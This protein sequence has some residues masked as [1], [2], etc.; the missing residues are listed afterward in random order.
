M[1]IDDEIQL[2]PATSGEGSIVPEGRYTLH[3][4]ALEKAPP[5]TFK[6]ED[7]PRVKWIF[8]LYAELVESLE[9]GAQFQFDGKPYEFWR[10]TSTKN[11]PRAFAR[12]YAEALG[13][14][15]LEDQEVPKLGALIGAKMSAHFG[16]DDD[17]DDP[18]RKILTL[19][20]LRHVSPPP[21]AAATAAAPKAANGIVWPEIADDIDRKLTVSKLRKSYERL[22]K[23]DADAAKGAKAAILASDLQESLMDDLNALSDEVS[24]AVRAAMED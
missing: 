16:Y 20:G 19:T 17:P 7:G 1:T 6:P 3:L 2:Q 10:T 21:A 9:R 18:T 8:H 13:G 23:L 11:S 24:A 15:K 4:I 12:K 5:S 22:E 14:R